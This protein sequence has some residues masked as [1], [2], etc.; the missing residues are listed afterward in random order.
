MKQSVLKGEEIFNDL[1][2]S[3]SNAKDRII[4]VTAWFTDQKLLDVLIDKQREGTVVSV[5]IGDNKDN[6][7]LDFKALTDLGGKLTRI[8]GNG[9]GM[10]HQ[11]YCVID[12]SIGFHGSYNW[13]VN[14]RR[15]NSESV[16]KTDHK[17]TIE[18]LLN[19]FK[20]YTMTETKSNDEKK[21]SRLGSFLNRIKPNKITNGEELENSKSQSY[22][23]SSG[24]Q[25]ERGNISIDEVFKS[26]I[27]AEAKNTDEE[28]LKN[29]GY[30]LCKEVSG[31]HN[32]LTKSMNSLYHLYVSDNAE[33]IELK[34]KLIQKIEKKKEELIQLEEIDRTKKNTSDE[35]LGITKEKE[36]T[37]EK[38]A[39]E[40]DLELTNKDIEL[41]K[42]S[43]VDISDKIAKTKDKITG[44]QLE[45]MKP[46]FNWF[47]FVPLFLFTLGLGGYLML[48]Y[49]SSLYIMIYSLQDSMELIKAGVPLADIN[50]QVFESDALNKSFKKEGLAG[51]FIMLFFFVPLV[52]AYVS[53]LKNDLRE[54]RSVMD[55]FKM[56]ACYVIVIFIDGFIAAKVTNTIIEIKKEAKQIPPDFELTFFGLLEDLNF[57]LVFCLG[58][59][60]FIF[61][62]ILIE[63]LSVFFKERSPETERK[64]LKF[65]KKALDEKNNEYGAKID[66]LNEKIKIKEIEVVRIKNEII[67]VD[68]KGTF[69]P[70]EMDKLK[71]SNNSLTDKKIE[72]IKSKAS[73]FLNDIDNDNVSV[74]FST[75]NHRI[76]SF[77]GGWNEWLHDEYSIE[78]ATLMSDSAEKTIDKWLEGK[79]ATAK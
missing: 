12:N 18:E 53:H 29:R 28:S 22:N 49:S 4:V 35:V 45:F 75:L 70:V 14:A 78:K 3:L 76:S 52:I 9:F 58:A 27:S 51:Y 56:I 48:F 33:N 8:K 36:I 7:K 13:T 21:K 39:L 2:E 24:F 63:K 40:K 72:F 30:E 34:E 23:D 44:L 57:W 65:Q 66:S 54:K 46:A 11:K 71:T 43:I 19:D 32:V 69:L 17:Q 68:K 79:E 15:N 41:N 5:V 42:N 38:A 47:A 55:I 16:I 77:I 73:L 37:F 62:S 50:P 60:P 25:I 61:L 1:S 64:K 6:Q 67:Q 31:D 26:I 20:K 10:M 74:S 59:L